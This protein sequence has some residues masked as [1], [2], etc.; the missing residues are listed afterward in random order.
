[1]SSQYSAYHS[2]QCLFISLEVFVD[3]SVIL[4]LIVF[5][6]FS[7]EFSLFFCGQQGVEIYAVVILCMYLTCDFDW[8]AL[9]KMNM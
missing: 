5:V 1:M 7:V 8:V 3:F 2:Q 9:D 6:L 4:L